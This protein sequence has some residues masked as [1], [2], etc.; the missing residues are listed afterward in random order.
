TQ[1][2]SMFQR[3][4]DVP[5]ARL[6]DRNI[7]A[8]NVDQAGKLWVGYFDRGLDILEPGFDHV[9]H[10]E[11]DHVF[12]VNRIAGD[13]DGSLTAVATANGLVLFD[14]SQKPRRVL[15]KAEGLIANHVTDVILRP[16]GGI[17][18]ATPAGLTTIDPSG[19]SSLYA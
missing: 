7:S 3:V 10:F 18:A 16:G 13:N 15:G 8:L 11:D 19:T 14:A 1:S 9:T 17:T 5:G 4:F 2:R 12:C 6:T